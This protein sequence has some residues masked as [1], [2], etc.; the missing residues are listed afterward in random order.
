MLSAD[1][2]CGEMDRGRHGGRRSD[3][4]AD[5]YVTG[6]VRLCEQSKMVAELYPCGK[7]VMDVI[8]CG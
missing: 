1:V 4:G 5:R 6:A 2:A 8:L 3:R 7:V